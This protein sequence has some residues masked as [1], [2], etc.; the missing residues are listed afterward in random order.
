MRHP[1]AENLQEIPACITALQVGRKQAL[2]ASEKGGGEGGW[3]DREVGG[4]GVEWRRGGCW[5]GEGDRETQR[6]KLEKEREIERDK[7]TE[8]D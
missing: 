5:G 2:F 3:E 6:Q 8:T 1:T 7:E 4:T